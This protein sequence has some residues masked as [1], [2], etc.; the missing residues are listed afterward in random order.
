LG[1]KTFFLRG[2]SQVFRSYLEHVLS[3]KNQK[4]ATYFPQDNGSAPP[5]TYY[6]PPTSMMFL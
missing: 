1:G 5:T 4:I 3:V 6:Q 2:K